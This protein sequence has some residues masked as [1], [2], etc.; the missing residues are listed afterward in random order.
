MARRIPIEL[1][2]D[3]KKFLVQ[4]NDFYLLGRYS[5][6]KQ[7]FRKICTSEFASNNLTEIK[8]FQQ[9]LLNQF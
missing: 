4:V 1:T 3:Q 6:E 8:E 5:E 7:A 2:E 9:W